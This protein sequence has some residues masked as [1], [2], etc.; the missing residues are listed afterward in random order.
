MKCSG[1]FKPKSQVC[2][3]CKEPKSSHQTAHRT[4]SVNRFQCQC[5]NRKHPDAELCNNCALEGSMQPIFGDP[6]LGEW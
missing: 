4:L 6:N 2:E 1:L 3:L 5:G